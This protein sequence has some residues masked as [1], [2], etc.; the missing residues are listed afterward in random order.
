MLKCM[1]IPDVV[2]D[3]H[4][5]RA[6]SACCCLRRLRLK[7]CDFA[8][9]FIPQEELGKLLSASGDKLAQ[10]QAAALEQASRIQVWLPLPQHGTAEGMPC[11][12]MA[13]STCHRQ[14]LCALQ[15]AAACK[16]CI[17]VFFCV[18]VST[19]AQHSTLQRTALQQHLC[20]CSQAICRPSTV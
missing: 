3:S 18:C 6:A 15:C 20:T 11:W 2:L 17:C 12:A 5:H 1:I 9:D 14:G 13:S 19:T 10:D 8:Q 7:A 16:S 4:G